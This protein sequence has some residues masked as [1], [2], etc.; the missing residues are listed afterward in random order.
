M[1]A[2]STDATRLAI[3]IVNYR[4]GKM[5]IAAVQSVLDALG[6]ITADVIVVDNASGDGSA[7][8]IAEWMSQL[9]DARVQ[10]VRSDV[11][12]GFSGGHN[13]GMKSAPDADY[14]LVLNSDALLR[15]DFFDAILTPALADPK[16]GLVAP[17]LEYD[18]GEIQISC[19]R[20]ASPASEVMRG[21]QTGPVTKLLKHHVIAIPNPP[22]PSQIEW[23]SFACILLC[24]DMVKD[25]GPMDEGYFLY[26]EDSEYALRATRAGWKVKH[27]AKARAVHFRGGSGPVKEIQAE[28]KRLPAYYWRSRT[29]FLRQAYGRSGPLRGNLG[30]I[31]GRIIAQT[32]RL[33]GRTVP[34][35]HD[36]EWG[37]I[38]I[39]FTDPL[40]PDLEPRT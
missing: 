40:K 23:A 13:L 10:L 1:T 37:D 19:F 18:D 7:E 9:N 11:N 38:W 33:T 30:W 31:L 27:T 36:H 39:G 26:F 32:R 34:A 16:V 12:S 3:S 29:R 28:K 4:T 14:Y 8:S 24:G 35:I 25:I 2:R 21:A 22:V 17:Q 6:D 5:T 15:P 20:F